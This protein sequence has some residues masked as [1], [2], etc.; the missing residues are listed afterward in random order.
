MRGRAGSRE[1]TQLFGE[2]MGNGLR[3]E[4][5]TGMEMGTGMRPCPCMAAKWKPRSHHLELVAVL[6]TSSQEG[7]MVCGGTQQRKGCRGKVCG[8]G[9]HPKVASGAP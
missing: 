4:L 5:G 6:E 3:M 9:C 8:G 1:M 2:E 7:L